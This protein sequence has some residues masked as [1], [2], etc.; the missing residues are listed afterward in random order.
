MS[1]YIVDRNHILDLGAAATSPVIEPTGKFSWFYNGQWHDVRSAQAVV[2]GE[3]SR[4]G[5]DVWVDHRIVYTALNHRRDS[6]QLAM[7][8][9]DR[10]SLRELRRFCQRTA[11]EIAEER[12]GIFAGVERIAPHLSKRTR[13]R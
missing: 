5:Y 1:A 10:L 6:Q 13:D 2:S 3:Y 4:Y 12:G 7:C 11:R 8:E 9:Q